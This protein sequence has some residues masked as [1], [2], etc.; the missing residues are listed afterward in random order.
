L[1]LEQDLRNDVTKLPDWRLELLAEVS[2]TTDTQTLE[3][4]VKSFAYSQEDFA[5]A[6]ASLAAPKLSSR[7]QAQEA[8]RRMGPASLPHIKQASLNADAETQMRLVAVAASFD[9]EDRCH[10]RALLLEAVTGLL[11]E[12]RHPGKEHASRRVYR[13]LFA[14]S[15][16]SLAGGYRGMKIDDTYKTDGVVTDGML[17]FRSTKGEEDTDH[18]LLLHAKDCTGKEEFPKVLRFQVKIGG[19][20]GRDGR[21]HVGLSLGKVR[22]LYHPGYSGGAFRFQNVATAKQFTTNQAMGFTP[23]A[24]RLQTMRCRVE[25]LDDGNVKWDVWI[26]DGDK[27]FEKSHIFSAEEFGQVDVLG[28]DRSGHTGG[29]AMFDELLVEW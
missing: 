5:R 24:G 21:Y 2:L 19:G 1:A 29:A 17:L 11:Y 20:V 9:Q 26:T 8:I 10:G 28:L 15:A 23:A 22:A 3:R 13:E 6:V 12:R 18:R 27:T 16:A 4:I 14:Q 7:R 25:R